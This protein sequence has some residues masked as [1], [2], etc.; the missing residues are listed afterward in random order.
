MGFRMAV[1]LIKGGHEVVAFDVMPAALERFREAGGKV[2]ASPAE[3]ADGSSAVVTML[4]SNQHVMDAYIGGKGVLETLPKGGLCVDSSTIDPQVARNVAQLVSEHGSD[5]VDAPVSG[6]VNGAEA[7]TLTFMVGGPDHV[8]TKSQ[9]LLSH[10]G[11]N[12]V[13]CGDVGTGQVAK[14]CNNM[15]LGISMIGVSEAMNLGSKLGMDRSKLAG[16]LNT[17]TAR[18]WSSDTYNPA[19]GVMEGVPSSRGYEGGFGSALMLKDLGLVADAAKQAGAPIPMGES[20]HAFYQLLVAN[21]HGPKDFSVAFKFLGGED[22]DP[23]A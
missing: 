17:S 8:F 12:L 16:I 20:A 23:K 2:A 11:K 22:K 15:V 18:C 9:D 4:P 3:A 7:G 21:G 5:F 1:N 19:P 14:L 10:M 13:H 6:G